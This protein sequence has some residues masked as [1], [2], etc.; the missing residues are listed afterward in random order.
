MTAKELHRSITKLSKSTAIDATLVAAWQKAARSAFSLTDRDQRSCIAALAEL[1]RT[2]PGKDVDRAP[3]GAFLVEAL[4]NEGVGPFLAA[5][6]FFDYFLPAEI[7][8]LLAPHA[9]KLLDAVERGAAFIADVKHVGLGVR[10]QVD[11]AIEKLLCIADRIGVPNAERARYERLAIATAHSW[12]GLEGGSDFAASS[13]LFLPLLERSEAAVLAFPARP[14]YELLNA[15][16]RAGHGAAV[17]ERV[18]ANLGDAPSA[19]AAAGSL[20]DLDTA[21]LNLEK[22][23]LARA[24]TAIR[25]HAATLLTIAE[26]LVQ[27]SAALDP[28]GQASSDTTDA[29]A[30]VLALLQKAGA[31]TDAAH[32]PRGVA[33]IQRQAFEWPKE[34]PS[35]N[36]LRNLGAGSIPII[37]SILRH[38]LPRADAKKAAQSTQ[39]SGTSDTA[40]G[41]VE[42]CLYELIAHPDR[43][44]AQSALIAEARAW[45]VAETKVFLTIAGSDAHYQDGDG[46]EKVWA[47]RGPVIAALLPS[48]PAAVQKDEAV[49]KLIDRARKVFG[50][51]PAPKF[52][53]KP[54][55]TLDDAFELLRTLGIDESDVPIGKGASEAD[56]AALPE[57]L[58]PL[59]LRANGV[60]GTKIVK[61]KALAA[62]ARRFRSMLDE[63]IRE[64]GPAWKRFSPPAELVPIGTAACGDVFFLDPAREGVVFRFDHEEQEPEVYTR[65]IAAFVACILVERWGELASQ[66]KLAQKTSQSWR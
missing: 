22:K 43:A 30:L 33:L 15:L 51:A 10:R 64:T 7:D 11:R 8:A 46:V 12:P 41:Y 48:I 34:Q 6:T 60:G 61:V 47:K 3:F 20:R 40:L 45:G 21:L 38:W 5:A 53:K 18:V 28:E 36:L 14:G 39:Y 23:P 56:V 66:V 35:L 58:Q 4:S 24:H 13:D 16:I 52:A 44:A 57:V 59:Y 37:A 50:D 19:S 63:A 25:A 27:Q 31:F 1:V 26:A 65:T 32:L 29:L 62:L 49:K 42:E 2:I 17:V 54:P 9:S 55:A